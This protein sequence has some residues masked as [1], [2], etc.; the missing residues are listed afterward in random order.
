MQSL[1]KSLRSI[2]EMQHQAQQEDI[3]NFKS[4]GIGKPLTDGRKV[5]KTRQS[6]SYDQRVSRTYKHITTTCRKSLVRQCR[7]LKTMKPKMPGDRCV[8]P[9]TSREELWKDELQ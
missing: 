7:L 4:G 1:M 2:N 6:Y 3:T 8:G 9:S 5:L